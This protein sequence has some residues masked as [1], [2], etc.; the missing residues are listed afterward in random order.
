VWDIATCKELQRTTTTKYIL[1]GVEHFPHP[2]SPNYM[3][4]CRRDH[5]ELSLVDTSQPTSSKED[6]IEV[7]DI[8]AVYMNPNKK[9]CKLYNFVVHPLLPYYVVCTTS[10]GTCVARI[11]WYP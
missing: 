5:G 10:K 3:L 11:G 6:I 1:A 2:H 4:V 9:D 7:L 8:N